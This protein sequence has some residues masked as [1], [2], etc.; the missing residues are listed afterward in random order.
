MY[1]NYCLHMCFQTNLYEL[2]TICY[3]LQINIIDRGVTIPVVVEVVDVFVI[4]VGVVVGAV[5]V[6]V[7]VVIAVVLGVVVVIVDVV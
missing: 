1:E 7:A 2:L 6:L 3:I 4:G 5:V